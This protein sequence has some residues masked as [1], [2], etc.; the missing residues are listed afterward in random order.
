M[1]L[2]VWNLLFTRSDTHTSSTALS[3]WV[4]K[5]TSLSGTLGFYRLSKRID[6]DTNHYHLDRVSLVGSEGL[7][8]NTHVAN[9]MSIAQLD[10]ECLGRID[11]CVH[12][13]KDEVVLR[14]REGE[15]A[16]GEGRRVVL[17]GGFDLLLDGRHD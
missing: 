13:C 4:C 15:V 17:R 6:H 8:R 12:A 5:A 2:P 3:C 9:D 7:E 16:L 11:S 14:R 1:L 10:P